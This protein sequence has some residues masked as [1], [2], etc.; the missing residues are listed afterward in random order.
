MT[1]PV[2]LGIVGLGWWGRVLADAIGRSE[3]AE[4]VACFA[5]TQE[6]RDQFANDFACRSSSSLD[7]LLTQDGVEGVLFATPHSKHREHVEQAAAA[8]VHAFVEKPFTL[9]SE[10][11]R[12]A[13]A[14]AEAAGIKL[15]VG[16]QR[17]RQFANRRLKAMIDDG[18]IG[19]PLHGEAT[20]FVN[21]GYPDTWRAGREETPLGGMTGLGVH[22][23][24]TYHY[25]L[26]PV[27]RVSAFSNNV[28]P[29]TELDHATGLLLN[30]ESGAVASILTSHFAPP[31]CRTVIYGSEGAGFNEDDGAR[32]FVQPKMEQTRSEVAVEPVDINVEQIEE[33]AAAIRYGSDIE[34]G[35][36]EGLAVVRVLEAAVASAASGQT[37]D[38]SDF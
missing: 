31:A 7:D 3:G 16:H 25:L 32:M 36:A 34:T 26:G 2:R 9:S 11:G 14:A 19:T 6:V 23:L 29:G 28:L 24:D 18:S 30:F 27:T 13:I 8:G 21:K 37:V 33:F 10:D 15:M 20:F 1:E 35:G 5:R 4:L 38:L 22:S 17:R 12:A